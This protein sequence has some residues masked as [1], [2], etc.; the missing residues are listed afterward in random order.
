MLRLLGNGKILLFLDDGEIII[1]SKNKNIDKF[2]I[3]IK[4]HR[5]QK[6]LYLN[7]NQEIL[8]ALHSELRNKTVNNI[9]A[10]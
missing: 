5:F 10:F 7:N 1:I 4:I 2:L 3:Y 9:Q 8:K 6:Q